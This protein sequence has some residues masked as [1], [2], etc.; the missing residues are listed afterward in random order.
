MNGVGA[1]DFG[2]TDFTIDNDATGTVTSDG[3]VV[4]GV[5]VGGFGFPDVGAGVGGWPDAVAE[6]ATV[7]DAMSAEVTEYVA[8]NTATWPGTNEVVD[9]EQVATGDDNDTQVGPVVN[10]SPCNPCASS[11]DT[12][13]RS[14]VPVSVTVKS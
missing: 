8:V 4:I 14:V 7:P 10:D 13:D 11:T 9:P 5:G 3:G 12:P 2:S 1:D 6:S